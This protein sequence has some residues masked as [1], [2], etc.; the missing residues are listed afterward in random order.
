ML[1]FKLRCIQD[2]TFLTV[3]KHIHG[4]KTTHTYYLGFLE[5][6]FAIFQFISSG[7]MT[8]SILSEKVFTGMTKST[9]LFFQSMTME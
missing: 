4:L 6:I 3:V 7:N 1:T 2:L 5:A 9:M 8:F